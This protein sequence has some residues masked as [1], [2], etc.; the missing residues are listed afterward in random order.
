MRSP[1]RSKRAVLRG[2]IMMGLF[3]V[4][5]VLGFAWLVLGMPL[6]AVAALGLYMTAVVVAGALIGMR[7]ILIK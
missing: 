2:T 1:K 6:W 4:A 3:C 7:F 5:I